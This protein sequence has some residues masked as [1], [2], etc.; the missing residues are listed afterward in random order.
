MIRNKENLENWS[1]YHWNDNKV[2]YI[3]IIGI[4]K[5][6]TVVKETR[7]EYEMPCAE[8]LTNGTI[9]NIIFEITHDTPLTTPK[10]GGYAVHIDADTLNHIGYKMIFENCDFISHQAPSVGIGLHENTDLIFNRCNFLS[11]GD[12]SYQPNP[13]Y[14][15]ISGYGGVFCH[16]DTKANVSN[17]NISFDSCRC[18]TVRGSSLNLNKAGSYTSG[19]KVKAFHSTFNRVGASGGKVNREDG[20]ELDY[21]SYGNNSAVLNA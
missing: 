2:R 21:R 3:S 8:P 10:Q 19:M 15:N 1:A 14:V 18:E 11:D 5:E 16:S 4:D 13:S 17:Q 12:S 9:A 7:G 6:H 20:I